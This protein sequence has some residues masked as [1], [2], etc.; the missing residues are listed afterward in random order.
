MLQNGAQYNRFFKKSSCAPR[1]LGESDTL[2]TVRQMK[3]WAIKNVDQTKDLALSLFS[4]K[5][6]AQTAALIYRFLYNHI[7]YELDGKKQNLRSPACSWATREQGVDC[8]SYS[9]F[10][11]TILSNLGIKHYFRR[12]KQ[13]NPNWLVSKDGINPKHWTHVYIVVPRNQ[14][15]LKVEN[16]SDYLVIDATV[17]DNKEVRFTQKSDELMSKVSLPHYGLQGAAPRQNGLGGSC[18][19]S[20]KRTTTTP[21]RIPLTLQRISRESDR[22][23]MRGGEMLRAPLNYSHGLGA[24]EFWKD[25]FV[26]GSSAAGSFGGSGSSG[27]SGSKGGDW[28]NAAT[29]VVSSGVQGAKNNQM[30]VSQGTREQRLSQ[31]GR[32]GATSSTIKSIGIAAAPYTYG[33]TAV[34]ALVPSAWYEKVL[35]QWFSGGFKCIG[36]S[37]TEKRAKQ[38][39][40]I[41]AEYL[42]SEAASVFY[43]METGTIAEIET[44][45]N[46]W[47]EFFYSVRSTERHW[48]SSSAKDCTKKGL[49]LL[50]KSLDESK[51]EIVSHFKQGIARYGHLLANSGTKTVKYPPEKHTGRHSLS[52]EV[53]QFKIQLNPSAKSTDQ[54]NKAVATTYDGT[55]KNIT[56]VVQQAGMG[57]IGIV[58][59]AALAGGAY[60][61]KNS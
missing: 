9:I 48:L 45:I 41:E 20:P 24:S 49:F 21:S 26:V 3:K 43:K 2:F 29:G 47:M 34:L 17:H 57:K 38:T 23:A 16:P 35:G 60:M 4:G 52:K 19:C 56:P 46:A 8:K 33:I 58:L 13:P 14:K 37:W 42:K 10:A 30:L 31:I 44:A 5:E 6:L 22:T 15:S 25:V 59:M 7:Q 55:N 36:S 1:Y 50:V 11:S 28:A 40:A 12:V 32:T 18:S 61:Y 53:E 39:V 51:K 54:I 27:G